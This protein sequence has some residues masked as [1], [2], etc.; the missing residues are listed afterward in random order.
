LGT[1]APAFGLVPAGCKTDSDDDD[2]GSGEEPTV[3]LAQDG[4]NKFTLTISG[5][6][7]STTY[8]DFG[9]DITRA[10]EFD[11]AVTAT[12]ASGND[13]AISDPNE[14]SFT[15]DRTSDT[16][17]TFT[18]DKLETGFDYFG[19][20]K[21][22]LLS[23]TADGKCSIKMTWLEGVEVSLGAKIAEDSASVEFNI[24]K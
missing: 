10:L 9:F 7:W 2:G 22:K 11:G 24:P 17:L 23:P 18:M 5:A 6:V 14:I 12:G 1:P 8:S 20:G 19:S 13:K 16:V 15:A 21:L 4:A 3:K